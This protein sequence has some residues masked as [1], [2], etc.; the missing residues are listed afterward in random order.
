MN[1][2]MILWFLQ[3]LRFF[4]FGQN[5]DRYGLDLGQFFQTFHHQ[6]LT[7]FQSNPS[8]WIYF[9]MIL[10]FFHFF[11]FF[12]FGQNWAR[13]GLDLGQIFPEISPSNISKISVKSVLMDVFLH[14]NMVFATF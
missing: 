14:D 12:N 10:W 6:I 8:Q 4:N 7:K 13:F 9:Y 3:L 5:W 11:R 1:C 2:N